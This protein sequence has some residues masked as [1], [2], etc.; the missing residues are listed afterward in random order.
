M[1]HPG[2][3]PSSM[4]HG[5]PYRS[6]PPG[7]PQLDPRSMQQH[8]GPQGPQG[9]RPGAPGTPILQSLGQSHNLGPRGPNP[10]SNLAQLQNMGPGRPSLG[11]G[12]PHQMNPGGPHPGMNPAGPHPN[13]GGPHQIIRDQNPQSLPHGAPVPS[14]GLGPSVSGVSG[15]PGPPT[16]QANERDMPI[17]IKAEVKTEPEYRSVNHLFPHNIIYQCVPTKG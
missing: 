2:Q 17:K 11:P 5:F 12:G 6:G 7:A 9:T 14:S 3:P 8:P 16:S 13:I 1:Q 4:G 15:A 10:P